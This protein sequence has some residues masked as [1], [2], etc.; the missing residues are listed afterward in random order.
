MTVAEAA[1]EWNLNEKT[2][3]EYLAKGYIYGI[4]IE[5]NKIKLP[6]IRRPKIIRN[7]AKPTR[8]NICKW[9]FEACRDKKYINGAIIGIDNDRFDDQAEAM[10]EDGWL[11]IKDAQ[12]NGTNTRYRLTPKAR[13]AMRSKKNITISFLNFSFT[14]KN[15]VGLGNVML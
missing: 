4:T 13:E 8:E 15:N 2:V 3:V 6:N 9:I 14:L 7:N 11:E 5:N 10:V 1:F 12:R